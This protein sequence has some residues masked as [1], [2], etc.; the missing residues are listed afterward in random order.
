MYWTDWGLKPKIER[1]WLDGTHRSILVNTSIKWPNGLALDYVERKVYW[2]DARLD[3]IEVCNLNGSDRRILIDR[4]VPHIYGFGL[5]GKHIYWTDWQR[6]NL[7]KIHVDY[8]QRKDI[9]VEVLP[10]VM[11]LKVV[12]MKFNYGKVVTLL[13]ILFFFALVNFHF[14]LSLCIIKFDN[15]KSLSCTVSKFAFKL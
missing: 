6:R 14:K 4:D 3:K 5:I 10:A 2:A 8:P 12:D 9:V 1:A 11:G 13:K 7:Q 15:L